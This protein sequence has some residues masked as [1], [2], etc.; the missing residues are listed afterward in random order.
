MQFEFAPMEGITVFPYR[1][2]HKTWFPGIDRYYSPFVTPNH[3]HHFTRKEFQDV[4]P[5]YNDGIP[6]IPQ[7]LTNDASDFVWAAGELQR[8]GY[9]EVNLNLG[10]PSGTV[11][12]KHRGAGFLAEPAALDQF[13]AQVFSSPPEISIS[14]KTRIGLESEEEWERLL[15]VYNR[16]P[17]AA[18]VIH[19]RIRKDFYQNQPRYAA[20]QMAVNSSSIPLSYNGD[21]FHAGDVRNITAKFP[22]LYAVM[23]GRGLVANPALVREMQGGAPLEKQELREFLDCLLA[24][25]CE[26]ISGDRNIIFRM[27]DIWGHMDGMFTNGDRYLKRIRKSR[28]LSDY[29]DAV[30]ALFREQELVPNCGFTPRRH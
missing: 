10:C 25:N 11:V 6:L 29:R 26:R 7:L 12:A 28:I 3:A 24:Q 15:A 14:V 19:P 2:I 1:R 27:L 18:L 23:C 21:L 20:F 4:L 17:I 13:F 8:M 22:D 5:E 9:K 30:S 16:W